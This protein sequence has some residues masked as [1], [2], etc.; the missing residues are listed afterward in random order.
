MRT[1]KELDADKD[2]KIDK[3]KLKRFRKLCT[4]KDFVLKW[5]FW[6]VKLV[7]HAPYT[8]NPLPKFSGDRNA[9]TAYREHVSDLAKYYYERI[10][11]ACGHIGRGKYCVQCV[12]KSIVDFE[13]MKIRKGYTG[14]QWAAKVEAWKTRNPEKAQDLCEEIKVVRAV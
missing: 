5:N 7:G 6:H 3:A 10:I 8:E 14:E 4:G 1:E 13:A 2:K 12:D 9:V 11:R